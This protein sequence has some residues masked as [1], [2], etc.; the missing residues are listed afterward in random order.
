MHSLDNRGI[1]NAGIRRLSFVVAEICR[2]PKRFLLNSW[3]WKAAALS[4]LFRAPVFLISTQRHGLQTMATAGIVE[5]IFRIA[6][7]G[8][9]ASITQAVQRAEPQWAVAIVVLAAIPAMTVALEAVVHLVAA[10]PNL[11][12]GLAASLILS[13]LASG[14]NWYSMRKGALLVG[15]KADSF[16]TDL[17]RM[18]L[19]I[20]RF[21]LGPVVMLGRGVNV[22]FSRSKARRPEVLGEKAPISSHNQA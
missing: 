2:Q 6:I 15:R 18:P 21:A 13:V 4:V 20:G 11:Q 10:T 17:A 1:D 12:A 22:I 9:D 3:N 8:I 19:L 16:G 7:T 5:S 14:F